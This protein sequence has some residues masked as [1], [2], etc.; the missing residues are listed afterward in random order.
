MNKVYLLIALFG[1]GIANQASAAQYTGYVCEARIIPVDS[2]YGTFGHLQINLKPDPSCD[3]S[4][5]ITGALYHLTEGATTFGSKQHLLTEQQL[6]T[7]L[8]TYVLAVTSK[9]R[10]RINTV[11]FGGGQQI[12]DVAFIN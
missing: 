1:L 11:W 10:V 5:S 4:A 7:L 9:S 3:P 2:A 8:K 6:L 12:Q